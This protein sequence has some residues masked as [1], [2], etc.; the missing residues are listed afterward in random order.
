MIVHPD[1]HVGA[2]PRDELLAIFTL[3]RRR[4][5]DGT[6]IVALNYD[7]MHPLREQF[8]RAVLS[9]APDAVARFWIEFRVRGQGTAPRTVPNSRWMGRVVSHLPGA[10]GYL[11]SGEPTEGAHV[12]A[13][14]SNGRV[15]AGGAR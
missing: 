15:Y 1:V 10:I 5:N 9:L 2:L 4:W 3:S 11:P 13:R 14:I 8:D 6:A 12:V 7:A